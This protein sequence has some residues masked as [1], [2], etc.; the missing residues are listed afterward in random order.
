MKSGPWDLISCDLV[1]DEIHKIQERVLY[2]TQKHIDLILTSGGTGFS[3]RDV[4][5]EAII[6]LITKN[7]PGLVH[8]MM[9]KSLQIT[10]MAALSRPVC[11]T[12]KKS[13]VLTLPGSPKG[14][15][16]N[17]DSVTSVL[18]HALDLIQEQK[19]KTDHFHNSLQGHDCFKS[20]TDIDGIYI[21]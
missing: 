4:T 2:W 7:A 1:P 19:D 20:K 9:S 11:G 10:Q 13:L 17:F 15:G 6:P 14:A 12:V 8:L 5:P 18:P 21:F 3:K 16:E